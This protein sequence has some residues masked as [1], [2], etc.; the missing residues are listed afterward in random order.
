MDQ[1]PTVDVSQCLDNLPNEPPLFIVLH[2]LEFPIV[3][4]LET[5]SKSK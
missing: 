1:L 2:G 5:K 3:D 4:K